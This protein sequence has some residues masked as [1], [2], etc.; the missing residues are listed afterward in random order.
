MAQDKYPLVQ[1]EQIKKKRLDE[2][3]RLLAEK[4]RIL[5]DETR[6]LRKIENERDKVKE[7]KQE[8]LDQLRDELDSGTTSDK[9]EQMKRYLDVVDERLAQK[10]A[11]VKEQQKHVNAAEQAVEEARIQLNR[12]LQEV[13]KIKLHRNEW[14][15]GVDLEELRKEGIET[16][17]LGAAMHTLRKKR[18]D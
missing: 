9:V 13:E 1:L 11:K 14:Q 12:K 7:H 16:D 2:A 8:K 3:E 5:E 6:K 17:E 18:G 4:K 10:E 15:K